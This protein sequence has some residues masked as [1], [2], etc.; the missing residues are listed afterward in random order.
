MAAAGNNG[1]GPSSISTPGDCGKII[2]VGAE[3]DNVQMKVNGKLFTTIQGAVL[4]NN[5]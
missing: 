4:Q 5:V 2:T 1:P 3:N